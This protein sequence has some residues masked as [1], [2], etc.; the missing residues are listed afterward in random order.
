MNE[1]IAVSKELEEV[2]K[3]RNVEITFFSDKTK[4]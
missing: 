3:S 1:S 4:R 2:V